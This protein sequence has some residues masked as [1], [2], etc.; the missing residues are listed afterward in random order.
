MNHYFPPSG[1]FKIGDTTYSA[2]GIKKNKLLLSATTR[3]GIYF[4]D[5]KKVNMSRVISKDGF[6]KLNNMKV[7]VMDIIGVRFH[8]EE[9]RKSIDINS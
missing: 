1:E 7:N 8:L 4:T 9:Y 2:D 5:V 3:Y 6:I